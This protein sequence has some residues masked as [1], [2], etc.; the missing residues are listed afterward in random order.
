MEPE[1][2]EKINR[3]LELLEK[4]P[5]QTPPRSPEI[6]TLVGALSKAQGTYKR[7]IPNEEIS[8]GKFAN[9]SQFYFLYVNLSQPMALASIKP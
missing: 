7:P 4:K 3:I 1:L 6:G 9:L 5:T 8:S 2:L